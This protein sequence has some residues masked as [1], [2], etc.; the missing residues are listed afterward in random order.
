MC[1]TYDTHKTP[2][3]QVEKFL[4]FA[5]EVQGV[6]VDLVWCGPYLEIIAYS[7][8]VEVRVWDVNFLERVVVTV[9]ELQNCATVVLGCEESDNETDVLALPRKI[10]NVEVDVLHKPEA[11][12]LVGYVRDTFR[13]DAV[14]Q[15]ELGELH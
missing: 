10:A 4:V 8:E 13:H 1:I 7:V 12:K 5:R 14:G 11:V 6:P 2:L 9:L 3:A 15:A